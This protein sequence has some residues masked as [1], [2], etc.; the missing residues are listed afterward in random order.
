MEALVKLVTN[1]RIR[2]NKFNQRALRNDALENI[3]S[4]KTEISLGT[5]QK[6]HTINVG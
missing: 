2:W 5:D 3:A 6:L 4:Q 1:G